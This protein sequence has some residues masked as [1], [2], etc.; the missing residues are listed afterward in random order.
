MK[1]DY[2][3]V[4]ENVKAK[5]TEFGF[6]REFVELG[7]VKGPTNP[8]WLDGQVLYEIYVRG[9]SESGTFND[10]TEALPRLKQMGIEV[11]WLMPVYP[12]GKKG[13]KGPLGSP[14]AV[15][16]YFTVNPE[17]G[18]EADFK[19]LIET[20]HQQSMKILLDMVPNHVALDY[21]HLTRLPS[22]VQYDAQG[23][24]RRKVADW[25]DIV[26]LDY[27][28]PQTHE[29]MAE[30]MKYWIEEFDVDGYRCDVAGLVPLE[31][32]QW[33]IPQLRAL[34]SDFFLLA[35]WES[36][37][38][39]QVGF[40]STYDWSTLHLLELAFKQSIPVR[41]LAEWVVTKTKLYPQNALPLRFL[42]N[43]DLPRALSRF[44]PEQMRAGLLLMFTL[45]GIPL[46]YNGQEIGAQSY[47]SLFEKQHIDWQKVDQQ[48]LALCQ[49]L[50]QLRKD[51]PALRSSD[52][53][54]QSN[55]FSENVLV[56]EKE[57]LTLMINFQNQQQS[58]PLK[59][60]N[61]LFNTHNTWQYRAGQLTLQPFQG[62][63]L[64]NP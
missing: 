30:V 54:F 55:F 26:D 57:A 29:H 36:Q 34:K 21:H 5:V 4:F 50:V 48:T 60:A 46:L 9:F 56:L 2:R 14:Y 51:W 32:W 3:N 13:R 10:V 22:L 23:K 42:E 24:P 41:L 43:H 52:Y 28:Q 6:L 63:L 47:L 61:V 64:H 44:T 49:T 53:R 59:E 45:H 16:D 19:T 58:V 62:V 39:H 17:Y 38:L 8:A 11:L 18:T 15:Q 27:S 20:A 31:F 1:V 40:N 25:T 33:V 35:E 7:T 37:K 12:I